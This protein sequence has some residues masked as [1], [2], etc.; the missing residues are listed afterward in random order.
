MRYN[1]GAV[2]RLPQLL[3]NAVAAASLM[4]SV[5]GA[6]L[7]V[8]SYRAGMIAFWSGPRTETQLAASRGEFWVYRATEPPTAS[9]S[10]HLGFHVERYAAA[11]APREWGYGRREIPSFVDFAGFAYGSGS[12]LPVPGRTVHL[13]IVPCWAPTLITFAP[14][15]LWLRAR[16]RARRRRAR[17][18]LG[19][20]PTCGYDLRATSARCPE[21]GTAPPANRPRALN[22]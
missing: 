9:I 7:W 4:L 10:P 22:N 5:A 12:Y 18:A 8:R 6:L 3:L 13:L 20:C 14:A 11:N 16:V 19:L 21:C 15:A 2:R 17:R 1:R